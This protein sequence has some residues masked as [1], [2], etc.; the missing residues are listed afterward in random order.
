MSF[1]RVRVFNREEHPIISKLFK[2]PIITRIYG[3]N[4]TRL[5]YSGTLQANGTEC[6]IDV[7]DQH[8]SMVEVMEELPS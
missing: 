8:S 5:S 3:A 1:V 6:T 4:G 2:G 7:S